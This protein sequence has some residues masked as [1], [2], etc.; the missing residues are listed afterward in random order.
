MFQETLFCQL[1]LDRDTVLSTQFDWFTD[2]EWETARCAVSF[3]VLWGTETNPEVLSLPRH[4]FTRA[5]QS[6]TVPNGEEGTK[7]Y[8]VSFPVLRED[9]GWLKYRWGGPEGTAIRNKPH[10]VDY[11]QRIDILN[12]HRAKAMLCSQPFDLFSV[13]LW[14]RRQT[15]ELSLGSISDCTLWISSRMDGV[16]NSYPTPHPTTFSTTK[17]SWVAWR[18]ICC[19]R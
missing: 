18:W 8:F 4:W 15:K 11:I 12:D 17:T 1:W 19:T 6:E 13:T 14:S 5:S 7:W 3:A 16:T 10:C 2:S 9:S